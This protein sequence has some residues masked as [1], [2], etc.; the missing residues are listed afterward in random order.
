MGFRKSGVFARRESR[1]RG[2]RPSSQGG[3]TPSLE[4]V[5]KPLTT[6]VARLIRQTALALAETPLNAKAAADLARIHRGI[7]HRSGIS[8]IWRVHH[9]LF[10]RVKAMEIAMQ[11]YGGKRDKNGTWAATGM[12]ADKVRKLNAEH[13]RTVDELAFLEKEYARVFKLK[14]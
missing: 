12:L 5:A 2:N 9:L 10:N 3:K 13:A 8:A 14:E 4:V 7:N 6:K 11:T 1:A